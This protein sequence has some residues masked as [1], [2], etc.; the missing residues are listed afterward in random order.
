MLKSLCDPIIPF[1]AYKLTCRYKLFIFF[2]FRP[3]RKD[4]LEQTNISIGGFQPIHRDWNDKRHEL[5]AVGQNKKSDQQSIYLVHQ[6]G[7]YDVT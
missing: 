2:E 6:R 4:K 1:Y 5:C 7:E 3:N